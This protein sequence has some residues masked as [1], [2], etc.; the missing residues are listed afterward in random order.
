VHY[1]G[2]FNLAKQIVRFGDIY[3]ELGLRP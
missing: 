3:E 1:V 2:Y